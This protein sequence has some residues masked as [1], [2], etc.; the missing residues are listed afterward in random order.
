MNPRITAND[1][2]SALGQH[3]PTDEQ[4]AVIE[5]PLAPQLVVAGAGSGK[6]ETMAARVVY[7]VANGFVRPEEVLGLT[8]T[9]KAAGELADRVRL[10]LR[11]LRTQGLLPRHDSA[12][13]MAVDAAT[14][15]TY[16]SFAAE[17]AREHVLRIG[18]DPDARLITAAGA[19]QLAHDVVGTW[20]G[21]LSVDV[22]AGA[23][24]EA[25]LSLAGALNEHLLT[26]ADADRQLADLIS[27][28]IDKADPDG[29]G[30]RKNARDI[31][32][33]LE[34]RRELLQ[35]VVE[36]A[37][38]KR[39]GSFVE[40]GDQVAQA[41]RVA[42]QVPQVGRVLREQYR[43]VLLDEYQDTSVAQLELLRSLFGGG[44]GVTAVGDPNQAIYGWRGAA[45][46]T[47]GRFP[48]DFPGADGSQAPTRYL[49]TSWRNDESIL[50]VA[51]VVARPLGAPGAGS[52]E[53]PQL[54]A[55]PGA[56]EGA[57]FGA[58]A[59]AL[60]EEAALV[61]DFFA[62][63]WQPE[64]DTTY[65]VLCRSRKQFDPIVAALR[66]RA[67]PVEIVGLG[68]LLAR[69][70][71]V[72]L[73]AIL[74]AAHD[75]TRGDA[76]MRL[77]TAHR[78]GITDLHA[79]RAWSRSLA[80]SADASLV[81]ALETPPP[82]GWR[83]PAGHVMSADGRR[84]IT[85]VGQLLRRV[86]ALTTLSLPELVTN[87][88]R[89]AGL[90]IELAARA[91]DDPL[92]ARANLDEFTRIAADFAHGSETTTL[93][94][95]LSWL[96]AAEE[97]ERGLEPAAEEPHPGAVQVLTVH[98]AKGLEWDIVAVPGLVEMEFPVYKSAP[99]P[100]GTVTASAWLTDRTA[101][102]YSLRGDADSLPELRVAG[103]ATHAEVEEA[104]QEFRLA[105]GIHAVAEERRL[106][107]VALTRA[108]HELLLAGSW[109]R[110]GKTCRPPS[111][112][113]MEPRRRDL[114]KELEPWAVEPPSGAVNPDH[115]KH[116]ETSWPA[117]P[118]VG[119]RPHLEEAA[120]RVRELMRAHEGQ[121]V[122][123]VPAGPED[124]EATSGAPAAQ[125]PSPAEAAG[126]GEP[127]VA[128]WWRDAQL[129]LAE[130]H[131][132]RAAVAAVSLDHHLS[133]TAA[134]GLASDPQRF[135][136]DRRRPIPQPPSSRAQ[137]GS[138]FH[139]WVEEYYARPSLLELDE[140]SGRDYRDDGADVAALDD[141]ELAEM[142][143]TFAASQWA[144]RQPVAVE[145][146]LEIPVGGTF[147]RCR[148]DAVFDDEH[149]I[150][151]VDWKT[152]K[153]PR[154]ERVQAHREL[155]LAIYRLG[156]ARHSGRS[157]TDI[158][159]AFYYVATGETLRAGELS[160]AE[161]EGRLTAAIAA[162]GGAADLV[163]TEY[164]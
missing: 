5:A 4:R 134:V 50:R 70:E 44:H 152:G 109:F 9:R 31:A 127:V 163:L 73:R 55:R 124:A 45:A 46:A 132:A 157:L 87:A 30:P 130:R 23:V 72:D 144:Q 18:M 97:R 79:L 93:G 103:A 106:A 7:L 140:P 48:T 110:E 100:D 120:Q 108:R 116:V 113:L 149:G 83:S 60:S 142:Q 53:V 63:R 122:P 34:E 84:R 115:E 138:R 158:N 159:A 102:P 49:R 14:I 133:A 17:I 105:A 19:W 162:A 77:L 125:P 104:H 123:P 21:A 12:D 43:L 94:A 80:D 42:R 65:A 28:L 29:K 95:F 25:V 161:I 33:S 6:T 22:G 85:A 119:R 92:H 10:R 67:I 57:V 156:W 69:P 160:E 143:E 36:F 37:R 114:L 135:A 54:A 137:I 8:F 56:G 11:Q 145:V 82:P 20:H 41:A 153:P 107:Y 13:A 118:L 121:P 71:I 3:Q 16:N 47:L 74:A 117:D 40:F 26:P 88:I 151:V 24:T 32:T 27:D 164:T 147:I 76:A 59:T 136:L 35:L 129:L 139:A 101:L 86:R 58:Y 98:A 90:D 81:D 61:A 66:E 38:R 1:L 64:G 146:D 2:A 150:D 154:D 62:Q 141:A 155:Q 68:G 128:R 78:L 96:D 91:G 111:R 99:R 52:V 75:P 148:I 131:A 39:D 15:S 126:N 89:L 112:F 51:N